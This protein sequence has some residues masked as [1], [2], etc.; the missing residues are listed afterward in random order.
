MFLIETWA[1]MAGFFKQGITKFLNNIIK[2]QFFKFMILGQVHASF[3]TWYLN[4]Y[5][6]LKNNIYTQK[7]HLCL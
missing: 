4:D 1:G 5:N 7:K 6:P 2:P 3:L